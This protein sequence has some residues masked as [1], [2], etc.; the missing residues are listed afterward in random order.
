MEP[1]KSEVTPMGKTENL[2]KEEKPEQKAAG[3][4]KCFN[5]FCC[6]Y[7]CAKGAGVSDKEKL[8]EANL[9]RPEKRQEIPIHKSQKKKKQAAG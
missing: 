5:I 9:S 4:S 7:C 1:K 2:K 6:G 3:K 8:E